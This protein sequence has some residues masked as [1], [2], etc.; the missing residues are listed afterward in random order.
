MDKAKSFPPANPAQRPHDHDSPEGSTSAA[1][2]TPRLGRILLVCGFIFAIPVMGV[3][4]ILFWIYGTDTHHTNRNSIW[5]P[6]AAQDLIPPA[7]TDIT[8]RQ[9]HLDHY[10]IY[11]ISQA[12]LHDFVQE[13][14]AD[15]G[16]LTLQDRAGKSVDR[17]MIGTTVG[18]FGW[19]VTK[20]TIVYSYIKRNGTLHEYY[21]DVK[22]GLTYQDSAYW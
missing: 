1:A 14:F 22:T 2:E 4:L 18:P 15:K 6:T 17:E 5:W 12:D 16:A 3:A 11:T 13:H 20:D 10:A 7:A 19:L 8:L 21:H 9:D